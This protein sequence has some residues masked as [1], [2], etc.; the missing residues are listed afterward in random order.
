[1][2][3]FKTNLALHILKT[4]FPIYST[5]KTKVLKVKEYSL[6]ACGVMAE[7]EPSIPQEIPNVRT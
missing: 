2:T 1:M 6:T 5:N 3:N 7:R 4:R